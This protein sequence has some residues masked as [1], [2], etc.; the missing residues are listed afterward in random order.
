MATFMAQQIIKQANISLAAGQSKY[1]SYF[2]NTTL[3]AT[4]K[5]DTDTILQTTMTAKYPDGYGACIVTM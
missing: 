4:Y 3:Y 1:R 5:A 2:V